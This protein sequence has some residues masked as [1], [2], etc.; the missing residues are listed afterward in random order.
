MF[1]LAP[2]VECIQ[3]GQCKHSQSKRTIPSKAPHDPAT[4]E[5]SRMA[6]G[7]AGDKDQPM[8]KPLPSKSKAGV[9]ARSSAEYSLP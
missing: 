4:E 6:G 1:L 7:K 9:P 3:P 8:E 5:L 2:F